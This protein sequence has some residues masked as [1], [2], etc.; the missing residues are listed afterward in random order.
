VKFNLK[1]PIAKI[2]MTWDRCYYLKNIFAKFFV[3][4]FDHN[5][6][7]SGNR[8]FFR[9]KLAKVAENCDH[10]IDPGFDGLCQ[11]QK[12]FFK[13][14]SVFYR[15]SQLNAIVLRPIYMDSVIFSV[16]CDSRIQR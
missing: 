12:L 10:S 16:R 5:I 7:F 15:G 4:I 2:M 8:Q 1:E 3:K 9:Q 13:A 6:G 11:H 14:N